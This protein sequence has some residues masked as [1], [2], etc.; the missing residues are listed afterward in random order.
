MIKVITRRKCVI[1]TFSI[2]YKKNEA[3]LE[4]EKQII[5][6]KISQGING[7]EWLV[8][9]VVIDEN[10]E[11]SLEMWLRHVQ[12]RKN[13]D[14]EF[15]MLDVFTMGPDEFHEKHNINWWISVDETLTCL[16]LMRERHYD[17]YFKFLNLLK[18]RGVK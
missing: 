18:K 13:K 5:T 16:C 11:E 15:I 10:R 2:W 4:M 6:D 14:P 3:A 8:L 7:I 9:Q 17:A 12:R 1:E